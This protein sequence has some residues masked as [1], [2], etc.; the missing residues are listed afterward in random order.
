MFSLVPGNA[1][2]LSLTYYGD[3]RNKEQEAHYW[4]RTNKNKK[5]SERFKPRFDDNIAAI[6]PFEQGQVAV[7]PQRIDSHDSRVSFSS[8]YLAL[9]HY[10]FILKTSTSYS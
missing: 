1:T 4:V 10:L 2:R 6:P 8:L 7:D 5:V 3:Q 9:L